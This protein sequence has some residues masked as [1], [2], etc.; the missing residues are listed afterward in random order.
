METHQSG[1]Y[2]FSY[3]RVAYT[4]YYYLIFCGHAHQFSTF[5]QWDLPLVF[6]YKD[7]EP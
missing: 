7:R 3:L 5:Q 2:I 1:L 6:G 4:K